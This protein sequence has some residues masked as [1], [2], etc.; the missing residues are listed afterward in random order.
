MTEET[1]DE[2]LDHIESSRHTLPKTSVGVK[3]SKQLKLSMGTDSAQMD[4]AHQIYLNEAGPGAYDIPGA[5][6]TKFVDSKRRNGAAYTMRSHVKFGY[7]PE[8][9]SEYR[10]R[11]SPCVGKYSPNKESIEKRS[12]YAVIARAPKL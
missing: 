4:R 2:R 5:F 3:S 10:G 7:S 11:H 1:D 6:S 12:K 9:E 8:I